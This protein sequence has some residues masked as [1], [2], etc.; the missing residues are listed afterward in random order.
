MTLPTRLKS[1]CI[2]AFRGIPDLE[3]Q[4]DGKNLLLKGDNGTG[5]SSIVDALEFFF[6]G[7]VSHLEEAQ[8]ISVGKHAPHVDFKRKDVK[9]SI[10]INPGTI[11]LEKTFQN[12]VNPPLHSEVSFGLPVEGDSSLDAHSYSCSSSVC[13]LRDSE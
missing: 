4:L 11:T 1:I 8:G 6:T 10:T 5:K 13:L 9:I 7:T 3:L 12:T 2:H